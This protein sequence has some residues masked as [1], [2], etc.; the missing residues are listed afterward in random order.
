MPIQA[1]EC[2]QLQAPGFP[3]FEPYAHWYPTMHGPQGFEFEFTANSSN[4]NLCPPVCPFCKRTSDSEPPIIYKYFFSMGQ[5]IVDT[6]GHLMSI[7][8]GNQR[9][10]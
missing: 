5:D 9:S 2:I 1:G 7:A 6:Q 3:L 8:D 10:L 4:R